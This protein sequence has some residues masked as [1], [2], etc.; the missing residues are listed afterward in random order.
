MAKN[1]IKVVKVLKLALLTTA[2]LPVF[3]PRFFCVLRKKQR[4]KML[5]SLF[6][7]S[8]H[9]QQWKRNGFSST[10]WCP[11]IDVE[12]LWSWI[13]SKRIFYLFGVWWT[14]PNS[15]F[16]QISWRKWLCFLLSLSHG[17][18]NFP[19]E[20]WDVTWHHLEVLPEVFLSF[21][22]PFCCFF[23]AFF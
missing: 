9:H 10:F 1:G 6:S 2:G 18:Q 4:R 7:C 20:V 17:P 15:S 5:R 12:L 8:V 16:S 13:I 19:E 11:S 3:S 21:F 14:L 22:H 23:F